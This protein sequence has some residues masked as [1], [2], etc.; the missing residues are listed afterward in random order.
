MP[1]VAPIRRGS[2]YRLAMVFRDAGELAVKLAE[3]KRSGGI[4]PVGGGF[5]VDTAEPAAALG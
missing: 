5:V 2:L 1:S 4:R 3:P